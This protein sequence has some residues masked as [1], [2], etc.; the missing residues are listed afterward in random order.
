MIGGVEFLHHACNNVHIRK[1]LADVVLQNLCLF[2]YIRSRSKWIEEGEQNSSYFFRLEKHCSKIST[3]DKLNIDNC[4][5]ED[6]KQIPD[7]CAAFYGKLYRSDYSEESATSF[8]DMTNSCK[9]LSDD[10]RSVCDLIIS[11]EEVLLAIQA[12]KNNKSPGND[13]ITAEL[14]KA[15]AEQLSPFLTEVFKES[16][17]KESLPPTMTQ[18]I[19]TL[20]PKP[21]KDLLLI[22]SW[23]PITLQRNLPTV[24]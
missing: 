13:G 6:P 4:L 23:R 21:K 15:F 10:D 19:I 18:G 16:L 22:D 5:T 14:Y 20:I 1:T 24:F 9:L 17:E 7:Y 3:I 11:S 12:L 2:F 8:L